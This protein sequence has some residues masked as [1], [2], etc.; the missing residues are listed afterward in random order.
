M[1][2]KI[3]RTDDGINPTRR[4]GGEGR[5]RLFYPIDEVAWPGLAVGERKKKWQPA[6][7]VEG[8]ER[9]GSSV[10]GGGYWYKEG[11]TWVYI[12]TPMGVAMTG[13]GGAFKSGG[14]DVVGAPRC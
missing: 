10:R 2:T 5:A 13:P 11:A 9:G 4:R 7:G 12:C 1:T 14:V 8:Q 3:P 6:R